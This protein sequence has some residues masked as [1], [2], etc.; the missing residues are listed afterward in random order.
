MAKGKS[1]KKTMIKNERGISSSG[2]LNLVF[3]KRKFI[4]RNLETVSKKFKLKLQK[5]KCVAF[6]V[7]G[8]L[9]D[10]TVFYH[11]EEVGY[12]R[13]FS[14]RDGYGLKLLRDFGIKVAVITGGHSLGVFKRFNEN[15]KVD[16]FFAGNEDK[17]D[18]FNFLQAEGF[19]PEEI[20]YMGDEFFD[21]PLLLAA[22]FSVA[23]PTASSEILASVDYITEAKPGQG[24]VREVVDLLRIVQK[25]TPTIPNFN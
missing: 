22:G 15:L 9:T 19:S 11:G 10:G 16:Y 1:K 8:V 24:A 23:P 3:N 25:I 6:D 5:I 4:G 21:V 13:F 20:L 14:V 2:N 18:A 12:N 17:R 7:D